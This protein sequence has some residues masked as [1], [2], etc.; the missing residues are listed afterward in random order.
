[1]ITNGQTCNPPKLVS[2]ALCY[3]HLQLIIGCRTSSGNSNFF[4]LKIRCNYIFSKFKL[5]VS[6]FNV[7]SLYKLVIDNLPRRL[8]RCKKAIFVFTHHR[9]G[10]QTM[11]Q[12]TKQSG[13][14]S[15]QTSQAGTYFEYL[16]IWLHVVVFA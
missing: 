7:V 1:M 14:C 8:S 5:I 11:S 2:E 9:F 12:L 15:I 4:P 3:R 6:H 16:K 13:A 10:N